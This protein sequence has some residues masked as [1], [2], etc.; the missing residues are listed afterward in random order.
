M[1]F[2]IVIGIIGGV[3]SGKS[4]VASALAEL[5]AMTLD[6][7]Q[8]GHDLL[9][10]T[11]IKNRLAERWGTGVTDSSGEID[12][13][14]VAGIVFADSPEAADELKFLESLVHPRITHQLVSR[15]AEFKQS[16]ET[17]VLVID[18]A[19]MVKAGWDRLCDR[20]V[21]VEVP[22]RD[23]LARCQQRGW[24]SEEFYRRELNQESLELKRERANW[25][26]DNSGSPQE[27]TEQV[28]GIWNHVHDNQA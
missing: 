5:G 4:S 9:N 11:E 14:V 25:V 3:G 23:R 8:I 18:A 24:T 7:D 21:F 17:G 28:T 1:E 6:V 20:L 27:L 26:I 22:E 16:G 19:V 2:M 12:R 15:I 13:S 10:E